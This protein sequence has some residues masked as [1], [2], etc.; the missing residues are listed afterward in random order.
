MMSKITKGN[1]KGMDKLPGM[2]SP[3]AKMA[4]RHMGKKFKKNKKKRLKVKRYHS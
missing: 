3:M 1:F 2:D 4:M